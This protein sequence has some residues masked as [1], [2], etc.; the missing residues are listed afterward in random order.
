[1]E[2]AQDL[3]AHAHFGFVHNGVDHLMCVVEPF[4]GYIVQPRAI[5]RREQFREDVVICIAQVAARVVAG[6][7]TG[8]G[9]QCI[10]GASQFLETLRGTRRPIA[11]GVHAQ[12]FA[13]IRLAQ[14][15]VRE[16]WW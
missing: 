7:R 1:M 10:V 2:G 15:R 11:V 5:E 16:A 6:I 4:L 3:C 13:Q 14:L 9:H 12:R 8:I